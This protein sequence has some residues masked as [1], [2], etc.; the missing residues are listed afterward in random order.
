MHLN[1]YDT[2]IGQKTQKDTN[3]G[4]EKEGREHIPRW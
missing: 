2:Q 1:T 4:S 3:N